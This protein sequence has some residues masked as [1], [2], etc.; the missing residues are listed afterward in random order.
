MHAPPA[1]RFEFPT[2]MNDAGKLEAALPPFETEPDT[3]AAASA[4][5]RA[6]D[7]PYTVHANPTRRRR[8]VFNKYP[9]QCNAG[10]SHSVMW[11]NL[12]EAAAGA[13]GGGISEVTGGD[14]DGDGDASPSAVAGIAEEAAEADGASE[15]AASTTDKSDEAEVGE[16][17]VNADI[18]AELEAMLGHGRYEFVWYTNPKQS[19][20][21]KDRAND[22]EE[23]SGLYHVQVFWHELDS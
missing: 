13:G 23:G 21:G 1:I 17:V 11:Y 10:T 3:N 7:R 18:G 15:E 19:I 9:Y 2:A 8:F 4:D 22:G 16:E 12:P 14:G 6:P 20:P 5:V